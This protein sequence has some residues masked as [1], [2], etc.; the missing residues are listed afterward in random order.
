MPFLL[1]LFESIILVCSLSTDAFG[2]SLTY[3][4][5]KIRVPL[6]SSFVLSGAYS[7]IL[8]ISL[9]IGSIFT[10]FIPY[11]TARWISFLFL[12][13]FSVYRLFKNYLKDR[14]LYLGNSSIL[15]IYS[16]AESADFDYSKTLSSYEAL[17]LAAS[18]SIDSM[19]IG[20][21]AGFAGA[22]VFLPVAASLILTPAVIHLGGHLGEK[23]T[24]FLKVNL[25]LMSAAL[26]IVLAFI[27]LFV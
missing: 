13:W 9:V 24:N 19:F 26:L 27:R 21:C 25:G 22:G 16:H 2:A 12:S 15:A 4:T 3:G 23:I 11:D 14:F 8:G 10:A 5:S 1:G 17:Y 20:F 7:C 6:R 18:L